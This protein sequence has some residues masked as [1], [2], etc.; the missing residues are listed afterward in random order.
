MWSPCENA[1]ET[2]ETD[3]NHPWICLFHMCYWN[4]PCENIC[5]SHVFSHVKFHMWN[6]TCEIVTCEKS[7][8]KFSHVTFPMWKSHM[9]IFPCEISHVT[10]PMWNFTCEISHKTFHMWNI[11]CD[12]SHVKFHTRNITCEISHV[13]FPMW[14]STDEI[15]CGICHIPMWYQTVNVVE[16][17][18]AGQ[19]VVGTMYEWSCT[20]EFCNGVTLK[21]FLSQIGR[22]RLSDYKAMQSKDCLCIV[23]ILK[24]WANNFAMR[25]IC[26][27]TA[28]FKLTTQ[29]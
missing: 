20:Y 7:H 26:P 15:T 17:G 13:E 19:T 29:K 18:R 24:S 5:V 25:F 14:N 28:L 22:T 11:T 12:K 27:G 21:T 6:F 2:H 9:W 16:T 4:F 23:S 8:G 10:F 3:V 1:C